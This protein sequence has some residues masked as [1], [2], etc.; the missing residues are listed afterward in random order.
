MQAAQPGE[1]AVAPGWSAARIRDQPHEPDRITQFQH[2]ERNPLGP[3]PNRAWAA[4]TRLVISTRH[5][6]EPGSSG[7][8]LLDVAHALSSSTSILALPAINVRNSPACSPSATGTGRRADAGGDQELA[9]LSAA[10]GGNR[11]AGR[12]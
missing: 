4:R 10:F 7:L 12:W 1:R 8:D 2:V 3:F 5:Q 6:G 11:Q 9:E